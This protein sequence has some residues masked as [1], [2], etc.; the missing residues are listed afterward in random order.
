MEKKKGSSW[1]EG[2]VTG[3]CD[4]EIWSVI[5]WFRQDLN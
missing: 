4:S 2:I 1:K 3:G 5:R